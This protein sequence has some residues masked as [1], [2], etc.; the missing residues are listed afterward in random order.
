MGDEGAVLDVL[1]V[2]DDVDGVVA[3]LAGPVV[4]VAGAVALVVTLDF[5]L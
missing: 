2:T 4:H 1:V 3:G 5:G